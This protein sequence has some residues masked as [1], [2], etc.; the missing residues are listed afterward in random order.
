MHMRA[1]AAVHAVLLCCYAA[2]LTCAACHDA[3][4]ARSSSVASWFCSMQHAA[5]ALRHGSTR[6]AAACHCA[7]L[8]CADM[9]MC[10]AVH[11]LLQLYMCCGVVLSMWCCG[12]VVPV[13]VLYTCTC[14]AVVLWYR[15]RHSAVLWCCGAAVLRCCGAAVLRCC[16]A[17]V[18]LCMWRCRAACGAVHADLSALQLMH[19]YSC[20]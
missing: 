8:R 2:V 3:L 7:L 6:P 12:A 11:V 17:A 20:I 10:A 19:C 18:L 15:C 1:A 9:Y 5:L 13:L 16:C 14:G 4:A